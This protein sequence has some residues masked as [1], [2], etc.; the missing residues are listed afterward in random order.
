LESRK[1]RP[2]KMGC[3]IFDGQNSK[4]SGLADFTASTADST[5]A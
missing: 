3:P 5:I 1:F 2:S 4:P